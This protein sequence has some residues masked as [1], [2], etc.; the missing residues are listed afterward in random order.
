[1]ALAADA[2]RLKLEGLVGYGG[3]VVD[4]MKVIRSSKLP[5][6]RDWL[7]YPLGSLVV[8][9]QAQ[10]DD[11]AG[12]IGF[13]QGHSNDVSCLC[14]SRDG[15][16]LASGQTAQQGVAADVL[17]WDL[18]GACEELC[19]RTTISSEKMLLHRLRQHKGSVQGVSINASDTLLA[20]LGG[21]DDNA[22]VV[23]DL[24]TGEAIC[25]QPAA[26]ENALALRWLH[27]NPDR[28]VTCRSRN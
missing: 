14:V 17:V 19:E 27:S 5:G 1:M 22:L 10:T 26:A 12:R 18:R 24:A 3:S 4:G 16:R 13:L 25:G 9:R 2:L 7:V 21:R 28:L 20:T 6:S 23:W 11:A 15:T 8:I